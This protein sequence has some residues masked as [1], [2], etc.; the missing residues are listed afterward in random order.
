MLILVPSGKKYM[1]RKTDESWNITHGYPWYQSLILFVYWM[2]I[3][4]EQKWCSGSW[5]PKRRSFLRWPEASDSGR[6]EGVE[7][8]HP[9]LFGSNHLKSQTAC[10][11]FSLCFCCMIV[12]C[13]CFVFKYILTLRYLILPNICHLIYRICSPGCGALWWQRH[14]PR[15][16]KR[17][18]FTAASHIIGLDFKFKFGNSN[19]KLFQ[20]LPLGFRICYFRIEYMAW[21]LTFLATA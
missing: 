1:E 2:M 20:S 11:K 17:Q 13:S 15:R 5:P 18:F 4:I 8:S 12:W 6:T 16:Q 14:V 19:L 7:Q 10:L 9:T 3:R 21:T